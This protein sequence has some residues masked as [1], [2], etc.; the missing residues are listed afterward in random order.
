M[1]ENQAALVEGPNAFIDAMRNG[2]LVRKGIQ[3]RVNGSLQTFGP[4]DVFTPSD[5]DLADDSL[6]GVVQ[7]VA[8]RCRAPGGNVH[9]S[10]VFG[11]YF[12]KGKLEE[13]AEKLRSEIV[14]GA[15][16]KAWTAGG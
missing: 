13:A 12:D 15:S 10:R 7:Q 8:N 16:S 14:S 4:G 11:V 1:A 9:P 6:D 3:L 2:V 5:A